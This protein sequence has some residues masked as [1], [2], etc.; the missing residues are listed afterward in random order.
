MRSEVEKCTAAVWAGF[1][2]GD[3]LSA[4]NEPPCWRAYFV[5]NFATGVDFEAERDSF[6]DCL[7]FD[8]EEVAGWATVAEGRSQYNASEMT[9]ADDATLADVEWVP[10]KGQKYLRVC[11]VD[12]ARFGRNAKDSL[13][14]GDVIMTFFGRGGGSGGGEEKDNNKVEMPPI[15][16]KE[17]FCQL[18][19]ELPFL[20]LE[21]YRPPSD[22]SASP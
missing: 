9:A 19:R 16:D 22:S 11:A 15:R 8:V 7:G 21:V 2:K 18:C 13:Q 1:K 14:V 17:L 3:P 6:K 10:L 4:V 20:S 5:D 12:S